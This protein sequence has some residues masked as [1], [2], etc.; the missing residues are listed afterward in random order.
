MVEIAI[1]TLKGNSKKIKIE[2][3]TVFDMPYRSDL[4]QRAVLSDQSKKRQKQGRDPMAGRRVA[5]TGVGPGKGISKI[6][7]THGSGTHHGSR[8]TFIHSTRG[9]KLAH[10][11][12]VEKDIVEKMNKKEY[13]LALKSA[14]AST[15]NADLVKERGHKFD[16]KLAFPIIVEEKVT[17]IVK[18]SDV[19]EVLGNLGLGEDLD[20]TKPRKV[21]AGKGKRRGRRYKRKTGPLIVVADDCDLLSAGRNLAGVEVCRVRDLN[22]EMLAPG[23]YA[24]RATVW[25]E[26]A[27]DVLSAWR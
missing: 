8:G 11:P 19:L 27:L 1:K 6:P 25:T 22:V 12:K 2:L 24:G 15:A 20:R 3:P 21:R 13:A 17:Q 18:T 4:I 9:G 14:V 10:P 26:G 23:T 16:D 5:A 7:R